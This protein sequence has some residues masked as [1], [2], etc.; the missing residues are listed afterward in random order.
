MSW[1]KFATRE[2]IK[3]ANVIVAK[4][5]YPNP[6]YYLIMLHSSM[7]NE[8][9]R[10]S[11][12]E[13]DAG[14]AGNKLFIA[15]E[16]AAKFNAEKKLKE[17]RVGHPILAIGSNCEPRTGTAFLDHMFTE[18]QIT[19]FPLEDGWLAVSV[20]RGQVLFTVENKV[21][22]YLNNESTTKADN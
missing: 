10:E 14:D 1:M 13:I 4:G 18:T 8:G 9:S 19:A 3:K 12:E 6:D 2:D 5:I 11:Y 17:Q 7:L 22:E 15:P 16:L 21:S 20:H